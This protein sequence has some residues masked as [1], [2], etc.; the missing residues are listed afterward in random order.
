MYFIDY[1]MINF[2]KMDEQINIYCFINSQIITKVHMH[3][4]Y[5]FEG[6][7]FLLNLLKP[8]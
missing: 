1:I 5:F 3:Y 6:F 8:F 7:S 2:L 4:I